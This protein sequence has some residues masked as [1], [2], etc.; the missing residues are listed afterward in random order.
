MYLVFRLLNLFIIHTILWELLTSGSVK[1]IPVETPPA[2]D[3]LAAMI[4]PLLG[5]HDIHPPAAA[6]IVITC[7]SS[8][9]GIFNNLQST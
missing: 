8:V 2:P 9:S 6:W 7:Q 5:Y 3:T 1:H 4:A